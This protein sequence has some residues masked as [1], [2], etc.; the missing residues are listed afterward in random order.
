MVAHPQLDFFKDSAQ[1]PRAG[2]QDRGSSSMN[3][4]LPIFISALMLSA[5]ENY[6]YGRYQSVLILVSSDGEIR[7]FDLGS[8][9]SLAACAAVATSE[10]EAAV[11]DRRSI[12]WVNPDFSYGGY[13]GADDW[14]PYEITGFQCVLNK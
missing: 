5:C 2:K 14:E 10:I 9:Y 12:F 4:F 11:D 1:H 3:K 7:Y 8:S 13:Q 6:D